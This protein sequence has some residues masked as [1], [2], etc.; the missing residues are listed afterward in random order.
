MTNYKNAK[1]KWNNMIIEE[2]NFKIKIKYSFIFLLCTLSISLTGCS[3]NSKKSDNVQG[4]AKINN[5]YTYADLSKSEAATLVGQ[6]VELNGRLATNLTQIDGVKFW[7]VDN[8][9]DPSSNAE[10]EWFWAT[11]A[12]PEQLPD[13]YSGSWT[14]FMFEKYAGLNSDTLNFDKATFL[15]KGEFIGPDCSFYDQAVF[16]KV[17]CIPNVAVESIELI[18][19]TK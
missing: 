1:K 19:G 9:H 10:Y 6:T 16:G 3:F 4:S 13:Q 12:Q 2:K 17:V 7:V 18:G 14:K 15:I 11:T 8:A 5:N